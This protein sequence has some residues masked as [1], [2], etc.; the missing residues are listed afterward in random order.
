V[1]TVLLAAIFLDET[2]ALSQLIGGALIL[3]AV[4]MLARAGASEQPS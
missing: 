1:C 2:V 4:I 3:T